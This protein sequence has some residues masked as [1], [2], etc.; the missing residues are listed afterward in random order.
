[1]QKIRL[2]YK[3]RHGLFEQ[4]FKILR[5][6]VG[7]NL[8]YAGYA[9][10][11]AAKCTKNYQYLKLPNTTVINVNYNYVPT[12]TNLS[13]SFQIWCF[14]IFVFMSSL[15]LACVYI[16]IVH[17]ANEDKKYTAIFRVKIFSAF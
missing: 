5:Q 8:A 15:R 12:S 9:P 11:K 6:T 10:N 1:M 13:R 2:S 7:I 16:I 4:C 14:I 17:W 3:A